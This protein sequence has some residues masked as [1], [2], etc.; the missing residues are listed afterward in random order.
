M[1]PITRQAF[2]CAYCGKCVEKELNQIAKSATGRFFCDGSCSGAWRKRHHAGANNPNW[3]GGRPRLAAG[4]VR[5]NV[6]RD[7]PMADRV[8]YVLEHRY[9]MSQHLGRPLLDSE[10]VHHINQQRDDNRIE[11]L[12]LCASHDEHLRRYHP[13]HNSQNFKA[14]SRESK[15]VRMP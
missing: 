3:K 9:V 14:S 4:Y 1:P 7:H 13:P 5:V 11:N 2:P 8:G 12:E 6:G 15:P 10:V